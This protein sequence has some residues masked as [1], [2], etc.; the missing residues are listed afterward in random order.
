MGVL[1][2]L[3]AATAYGISDFVGGFASRR[4]PALTVLLVSY[5][6]GGALMAVLLLWYRGPL[7]AAT[8]A[9][10]VGG[11]VAGLTGVALMYSALAIAPMNVVSPVTA[12]MSAVVPVLFGVGRGERPHGLAW[13]GIALGLVAVVLISRQAPARPEPGTGETAAAAPGAGRTGTVG[14][15][16][17][18]MA[19][20]AGVGF[21]MYFVCLASAD[22]DSGIWPVV[23]SRA[24]S[25]VLV[26]PLAILGR[27]L[28]RPS[29]MVSGLAALA[30]VLDATANWTF[31][32]ASRHGLLSLSGVI[33]ALYPAG[34]VLLA[35]GFLGERSS[36]TQR[37]GFGVATFSV[38][39]L[40]R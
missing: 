20:L 9:W 40:T 24:V 36:R 15:R 17:L 5:P 12:V 30:G 33:T 2:A 29:R 31:V 23:L 16:P 38:V 34:T 21:G 4:V 39:L 27:Q 13:L 26:V 6:I 32:L 3:I 14:W 10:S 11:G 8:V 1:F 28:V 35:M 18:T 22:T 7:S 19:V 37:M 25:A